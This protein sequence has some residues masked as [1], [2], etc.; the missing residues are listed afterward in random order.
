MPEPGVAAPG[1]PEP[2]AAALDVMEGKGPS[3]RLPRQRAGRRAG[4][5][6]AS[7]L[8]NN[9][10]FLCLSSGGLA[11]SPRAGDTPLGHSRGAGGGG[12]G[13]PESLQL[14]G[15]VIYAP[16]SC[17]SHPAHSFLPE[18]GLGLE[19]SDGRKEAARKS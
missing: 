9:A 11:L 14:P 5:P 8:G 13:V 7:R 17:P 12:G 1:D 4:L 15:Q 10:C 18:L 2:V 6:E 19:G 3:K 16:W